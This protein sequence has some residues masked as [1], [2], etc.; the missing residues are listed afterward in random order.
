MSGAFG[1]ELDLTKLPASDKDEIRRQ[2]QQYHQDEELIHQGLYYRLTDVTKG[3]YTAWQFV[4][5]DKSKSL[6]NLVITSP[7]PNP[8]PLH[9][10]FK[11]LDPD[12]LYSIEENG[13]SVSGAALMNSGYTFPRMTG[14]YPAAQLHL[15]AVCA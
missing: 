9:I 15:S 5:E 7:Q 4:S 3:Y 1:Y 10:R 2:V 13:L 11:G 6:V 14:D 12:T 8:E